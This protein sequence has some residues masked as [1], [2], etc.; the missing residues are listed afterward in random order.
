[1]QAF[2]GHRRFRED[3]W[4]GVEYD[5]RS[6]RA[7]TSRTAKDSENISATCRSGASVSFVHVVR[8]SRSQSPYAGVGVKGAGQLSPRINEVMPERR[9]PVA[10]Q[11]HAP[12][13][14]DRGRESDHPGYL[15][16]RL[17][18]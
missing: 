2:E 10:D 7:Q 15:K 17:E 8:R 13:R 18:S 9:E 16:G 4:E 6:A 3:C 14:G 11:F 1:M 12:M 5:K